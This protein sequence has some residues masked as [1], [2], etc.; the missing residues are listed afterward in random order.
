MHSLMFMIG[1]IPT[2]D[3]WVSFISYPIFSNWKLFYFHNLIANWAI[4]NAVYVCVEWFG[5]N[6]IQFIPWC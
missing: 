4:W 2:S 1:T 6:I 5:A 3:V